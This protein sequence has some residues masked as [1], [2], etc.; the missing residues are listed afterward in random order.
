MSRN[1]R[2]MLEARW[3]E[4]KFVCVGLDPDPARLPVSIVDFCRDIVDATSD[5]A[6]AFKP[7]LA[8]FEAQGIEG[9]RALEAILNAVPSG[10]PVIGDG[11]RGDIGNTAG[12]YATALFKTWGFDAA[13][14]NPLLGEDSVA[15]FTAYAEKGVFL[16]CRTSNPGSADVQSL[17]VP[18][19]DGAG[20]EPLYLR[21]AHLAMQWNTKGNV[22][23][24]VGATHPGE[25]RRVREI[26]RNMPILIPGVGAQ[27]GDLEQ[28]VTAGKDSRGRGMIVNASRSIIF[29]SG[30]PDFAE[31]ARRET[32]KLHDLINQLR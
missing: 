18:C 1:F 21:L 6:C 31:A 22:G 17:L 13:T 9:L 20:T 3:K 23:L 14:V 19:E 28:A 7:N 10:V 26:V 27:G 2:E 12:F 15:P 11:K 30:G 25:L 29:A 4:G 24:V 5:L 16:L 32:L 8:F